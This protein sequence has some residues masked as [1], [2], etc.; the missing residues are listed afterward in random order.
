MKTGKKLH[1]PFKGDKKPEIVQ[2]SMDTT[3]VSGPPPELR[4]EENNTEEEE[5]KGGEA[6]V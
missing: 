3:R 1:L 5:K 2:A 4:R 6:T